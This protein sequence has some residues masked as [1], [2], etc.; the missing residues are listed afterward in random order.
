MSDD[1]RNAG[2]VELDCWTAH[3]CWTAH[4]D[5]CSTLVPAHATRRHHLTAAEYVK[6]RNEQGGVC[7]ICR[8]SA[9]VHERPVPL[10]IDHHHGCCPGNYSC[11]AC[12]RGL[13]CSACN[14]NLGTL[15]MVRVSMRA[16]S[17]AQRAYLARRPLAQLF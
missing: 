8:Q 4:L 11:G 17:D 13:L 10:S 16:P 1:G 5:A 14:G 15:E 2:L 7:G 9:V 6:I 3:N 12:V